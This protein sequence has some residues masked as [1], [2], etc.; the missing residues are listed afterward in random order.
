MDKQTTREKVTQQ[1]VKMWVA[2]IGINTPLDSWY[3]SHRALVKEIF[4]DYID[5]KVQIFDLES[6]MAEIRD[7]LIRK[8][9][10]FSSL[11]AVYYDWRGVVFDT[12]DGSMKSK[13]RD[14]W[15]VEA[16]FGI[17][18]VLE[19]GRQDQELKEKK[20]NEIKL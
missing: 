16:I 18:P 6:L 20:L 17:D 11:K 9:Q 1:E 19:K 8:I 10:G 2:S 4:A 12:S 14:A 3:L 5:E 7:R 15:D 13:Y